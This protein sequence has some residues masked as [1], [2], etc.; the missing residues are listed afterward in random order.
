MR[1]L[2][3]DT[4]E[5]R[6]AHTIAGVVAGAL[7]AFGLVCWIAANWASFHRLAKLGLVGGVLLAATVLA[8]VWPRLRV[9]ALLVATTATGGLFALIGQIYP[10][11]ADAWQLFFYWALLALP[12]ALAARHEAVWSLWTIVAITAI[13]L[14]TVQE[15]HFDSAT[16]ADWAPAWALSIA[17]ALPF[18]PNRLTSRFAG[19]TRWAFRIAVVAAAG[20]ILVQSVFSMFEKQQGIA[21][22]ALTLLALGIAALS[23]LRPLDLGLVALVML[24]LDILLIWR[25]A[26]LVM[27]SSAGI[28]SMFLVSIIA[29]GI[30]GGSV[31]ILRTI[32]GDST[33]AD[34]PSSEGE[35][36]KVTLPLAV[37]SGVGAVIAAVPLVAL[38]GL[39]FEA[40]LLRGWSGV[41]IGSG[42]LTIAILVMRN[43]AVLALFRCPAQSLS[44]PAL[45]LS[46]S[47]RSASPTETSVLCWQ[48]S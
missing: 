42:V 36:Q 34:N 10:S 48:A 40:S 2:T 5:A 21:L 12:F 47:A 1:T 27:P 37:L 44:W 14:W 28:E 22:V 9:P 17:L 45:R 29:I 7:I 41:A 25:V 35:G 26:E 31:M 13:Q 16:I 39:V 43:S 11:G 18:T 38:F 3:A 23:R 33:S 32:A 15:G 46:R 20:L 30:V 24:A 6:R 4:I 19:A 8:A